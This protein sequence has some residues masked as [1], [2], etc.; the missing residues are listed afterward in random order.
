MVYPSAFVTIENLFN[1][2][3]VFNDQKIAINYHLNKFTK[4][5]DNQPSEMQK[6][7]S[8]VLKGEGWQIYD[9]SEKEFESWDYEDRV[10][11]IKDW[12]RAAKDRQI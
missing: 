12:L 3:Y 1:L 9:L 11:N 6:L 2:H 8:K 5:S 7:A 10:K 4:S